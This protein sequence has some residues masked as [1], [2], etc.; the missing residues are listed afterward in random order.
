MAKS[1]TSSFTGGKL[2]LKGDKKKKSKKKSSKSK[3]SLGEDSS[4]AKHSSSRDRDEEHPN[5]DSEEELT[6]AEKRLKSFKTPVS[7]T[8]SLANS[9][10]DV[11]LT[12]DI[13]M[14]LTIFPALLNARIVPHVPAPPSNHV[15][16]S[17]YCSKTVRKKPFK[18]GY[19]GLFSI[20]FF[21]YTS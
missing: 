10:H 16:D 20:A 7:T 15:L 8:P 2:N 9:L 18:R 1:G 17:G 19:A 4:H 3:H 14:P 21:K 13:S 6:T 12:S 5:S 11:F